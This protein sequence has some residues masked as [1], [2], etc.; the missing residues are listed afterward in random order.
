MENERALRWGDK[1][2]HLCVSGLPTADCSRRSG[3][4]TLPA[5]ELIVMLTETLTPGSSAG[6]SQRAKLRDHDSLPE[7]GGIA[8]PRVSEPL[9][10]A[11]CGGR[12]GLAG[13]LTH[14][15]LSVK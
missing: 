5:W 6:D 8:V 10:W 7:L 11:N 15:R 1:V 3:L 13:G 9:G 2:V 12:G 4:I 14:K